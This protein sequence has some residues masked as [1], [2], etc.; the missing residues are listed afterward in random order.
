MTERT[1]VRAIED[2]ERGRMKADELSWALRA[3]VL[4]TAEA[5]RALARRLELRPL[6]YVA[7]N[8]VMTSPH[9]LG[10]AE[11]SERLGI[12]TG[13]ATEL[14][15]RLEATGHL[16]R[17]RHPTD[18]RRVV[19]IPTDTAVRAILDALAP[20]F[21]DLDAVAHDFTP[22]EQDA[23]RRFLRAAEQRLHHYASTT[24]ATSPRR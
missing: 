21:G 8:H 23:I 18:R 5:D 2:V 13:S 7:V 6:D 4:A 3:V 22:E 14:V 12:S 19:L 17:D 15:D 10:P 9:P 20:L 11:L 1:Q 24:H 16:R